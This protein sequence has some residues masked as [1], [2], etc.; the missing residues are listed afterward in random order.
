MQQI[1]ENETGIYADEILLLNSIAQRLRKKRF[2]HGAIN[3]SSTEVKFIL[4][5]RKLPFINL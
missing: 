3:F 4:E 1:I 5:R 2:E